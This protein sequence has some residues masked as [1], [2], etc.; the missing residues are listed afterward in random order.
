VYD[1]DESVLCC[2]QLRTSSKVE[3]NLML[4]TDNDYTHQ[5]TS[6]PAHIKH[7]QTICVEASLTAGSYDTSSWYL[8]D[9]RV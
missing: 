3:Y 4:Y 2:V 9:T 5:L 6:F 8:H 1:I 7:Q